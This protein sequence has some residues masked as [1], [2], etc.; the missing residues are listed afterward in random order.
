MFRDEF[1]HQRAV[2][3][4]FALLGISDSRHKRG[5]LPRAID[6]QPT[7]LS[8]TRTEAD[9]CHSLFQQLFLIF[10]TDVRI[11]AERVVTQRHHE[12]LLF[13]DVAKCRG[14]DLLEWL[15]RS[16]RRVALTRKAHLPREDSTSNVIV[17]T[18]PKHG[19]SELL[20]DVLNADPTVVGP[21]K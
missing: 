12:I 15:C 9:R 13:I 5:I 8:V 21:S 20:V 10:T 2:H 7:M 18:V 11:L 3:E 19:A 17:P 16:H 14:E 1:L 6:S 4:S